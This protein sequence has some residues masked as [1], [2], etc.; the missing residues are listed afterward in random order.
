MFPIT[1][2][3]AISPGSARSRRIPSRTATGCGIALIIAS[4]G[5][6]GDSDAP[7]VDDLLAPPEAVGDLAPE[8]DGYGP[9]ADDS[10]VIASDSDEA[11]EAVEN[12][13]PSEDRLQS[14]EVEASYFV[15]CTLQV[16]ACLNL[17]AIGCGSIGTEANSTS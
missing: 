16:Q 11:L 9:N 3:D 2:F 4:L 15:A 5:C 17:K 12:V 1:V 7:L 14:A 6:S 8:L 10:N 13:L